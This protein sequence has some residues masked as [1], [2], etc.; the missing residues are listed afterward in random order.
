MFAAYIT[1]TF[2]LKFPP[3]HSNLSSMVLSFSLSVISFQ[4]SSYLLDI[5]KWSPS[6]WPPTFI[7]LTHKL[8]NVHEKDMISK[9]QA[10]QSIQYRPQLVLSSYNACLAII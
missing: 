4:Y 6:Q 8:S 10:M 7:P 3:S 2:S 9:E 1:N 5:P